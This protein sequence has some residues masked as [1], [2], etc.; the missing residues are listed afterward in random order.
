MSGTTARRNGVRTVA[1]ATAFA[2]VL[3]L[4]PSA[5]AAVLHDQY[6]NFGLDNGLLSSD[7]PGPNNAALA[8]DDFVVP[9]GQIWSL[10]GVDFR[11]QDGGAFAANV[12]VYAN[13]GSVP[14]ALIDSRLNLP[15]VG[16]LKNRSVVLSPPLTL[17]PGTYWIGVQGTESWGWVERTVQTGLPAVWMT[18][19]DGHQCED[20]FKPKASCGVAGTPDQVFRIDGTA[21]GIPPAT[22]P[23]KKKGCKQLKNKK[24]RKKCKRKRKGKGKKK[25]SAAAGG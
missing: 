24:K 19:Q 14:G 6:D 9:S 2:A 10:D 25:P 16:T 5:G 1:V 13:A 7:P 20:T 21:V 22:T 17:Q 4:A 3:A 15:H 12:F 8:A 23:A 18:Q 11:S